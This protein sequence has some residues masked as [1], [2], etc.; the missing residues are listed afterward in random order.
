L[1]FFKLNW[2]IYP[3]IL[4]KKKIKAHTIGLDLQGNA[5]FIFFSYCKKNNFR[6]KPLIKLY[7]F[8]GH[9]HIFGWLTWF[10]ELTSLTFFNYFFQHLNIGLVFDFAIFYFCYHIV[11]EKIALKKKQFI[12]PL[13]SITQFTSLTF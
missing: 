2:G 1:I 6:E 10:T 13:K 9:V 7:K 3:I 4:P 11:K 5:L 8:R 12:I